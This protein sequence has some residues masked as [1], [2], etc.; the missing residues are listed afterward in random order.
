MDQVR[1][2][3]SRFPSLRSARLSET[4]VWLLRFM[5]VPLDWRMLVLRDSHERSQ[6]HHEL[7]HIVDA[8]PALVW[9]ARADGYADFLNQRWCE[10]TGLPF[11]EALGWK[12]QRAIHPDDLPML[13]E[14]WEAIVA[15][16]EPGELQARIK[17]SDGAYRWFQFSACPLRDASGQVAS[18]VR[19]E[20]RY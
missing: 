13:L 15:S 12:W 1:P 8:L 10:Y 7:S 11:D 16:G 14:C 3:H 20:H 5:D 6:M 4:G 2:F 18:V 17:R 9:T 19:H